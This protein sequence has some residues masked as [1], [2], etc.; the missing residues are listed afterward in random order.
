MPVLTSN[1]SSV[2]PTPPSL[3][4]A[5]WL[6]S[7]GERPSNTAASSSLT[8]L[9]PVAIMGISDARRASSS[10]FFRRASCKDHSVE[11]QTSV[12]AGGM[13]RCEDTLFRSTNAVCT[14][15][16]RSPVGSSHQLPDRL[17]LS[18]ACLSLLETAELS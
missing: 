17:L 7:F 8:K 10:C 15:Q 6:M 14:V 12:A 4:C 9:F 2:I 11:G 18:T 5:S 13:H 16:E 3:D 1:G